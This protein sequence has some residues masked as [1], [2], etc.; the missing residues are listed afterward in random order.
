MQPD[1]FTICEKCGGRMVGVQPARIPGVARC[2]SCGHEV[3][4]LWDPAL[5]DSTRQ[6]DTSGGILRLDDAGPE[7]L[8]V[9]AAIRPLTGLSSERALALVRAGRSEIARR[10]HWRIWELEN[11]KKRLDELG[12]TTT[13]TR[14]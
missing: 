8:A 7:P 10:N 6:E 1:T 2:S 13:L 9:A 5:P 11:L 4:F 3:S 12:A 14:C